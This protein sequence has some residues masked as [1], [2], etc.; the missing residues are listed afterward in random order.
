[1]P[2]LPALKAR[3]V[4]KAFSKAGFSEHR[5]K[6]GSHRILIHSDGRRISIPIHK[7]KDIKRGT[8]RGII[9]DAGLSVDD[10]LTLLKG[11]R[12]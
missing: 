9:S 12:H 3:K 5:Q 7:G 1:M 10:F 11:K 4:I 2:R 8:L 6:S